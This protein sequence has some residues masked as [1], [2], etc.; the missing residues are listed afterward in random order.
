MQQ[1]FESL[2]KKLHHYPTHFQDWHLKKHLS[3]RQIHALQ[4]AKIL[5]PTSDLQQIECPSCSAHFVDVYY[6]NGKYLC[7]CPEDVLPNSLNKAD[8]A[9]WGFDVQAFLLPIASKLRLRGNVEE[10]FIKGLWELGFFIAGGIR[11]Y[12][13]YYQGRDFASA[14][15]WIKAQPDQY[16]YIVLTNKQE[17]CQLPDTRSNFLTIQ[18]TDFIS[19]GQSRVHVDKQFFEQQCIYGFRA[20]I[21]NEKNGNIFLNGRK[22][23]VIP[24]GKDEYFFVKILWQNFN[25]IVTHEVIEKYLYD[26]TG[27][28][29]ADPAG[30]RSNKVRRKVKTH[31]IEP[32]T[33]D[34]IIQ[35]ATNENGEHGYIMRNPF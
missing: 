21:F 27:K 23:N 12:C 35:S 7:R 17:I 15:K 28:R 20:V 8:I 32:G 25:E 4:E 5:V 22:V 16:R 3:E 26:I 30:K 9:T 11:H 31:E 33:T 2:L 19:L 18:V 1:S 24:M 13:Y 10:N 6:E 14:E 34:Q 29:L